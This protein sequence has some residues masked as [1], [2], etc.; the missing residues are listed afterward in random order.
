M[1]RPG[2][3]PDIHEISK[4]STGPISE[5]GKFRSSLNS[6]KGKGNFYLDRVPQEVKDLYTWFKGLTT[7]DRNFLFEL[8]G[9][10]DV[11]KANLLNGDIPK[12]VLSGEKLNKTELEQFKLLVDITEKHHKMKYGEK[13]VN[14]NL[15]Y[16]D[17]V[18]MMC[19]DDM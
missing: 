8:Q 2:G 5:I 9:I 18:D 11:L 17:V 6:W 13:K 12:K 10:Y 1:A 16:K 3:S 14:I 4:K 7:N 15:T 19:P